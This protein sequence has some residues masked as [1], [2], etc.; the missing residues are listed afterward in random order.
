MPGV[1]SRSELQAAGNR[2]AWESCREADKGIREG[3]YG[4]VLHALSLSTGKLTYRRR[5]QLGGH[6]W[7]CLPDGGASEIWLVPSHLMPRGGAS[8]AAWYLW[9]GAQYQEPSL[10]LFAAAVVVDLLPP[11]RSPWSAPVS[12]F[13]LAVR[14]MPKVAL[15]IQPYIHTQNILPYSARIRRAR[16]PAAAAR[17]ATADARRT[18]PFPSWGCCSLTL[19][20]SPLGDRRGAFRTLV[21][22]RPP[23]RRSSHA[24][25]PVSTAHP[26]AWRRMQ[27]KH[28]PAMRGTSSLIILAELEPSIDEHHR[29]SAAPALC[30]ILDYAST[31]AVGQ[32]SSST[33][34]TLLLAP[35]AP[36]WAALYPSSLSFLPPSLPALHV[37][38]SLLFL[39]QFLNRS[40]QLGRRTKPQPDI[41][42]VS[43]SLP[44]RNFLKLDSTA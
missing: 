36:L 1:N 37:I 6:L 9:S 19:T 2:E 10:A 40:P 12:A 33:K 7:G 28:H 16:C 4:V 21:D 44:T 26:S 41:H 17:G 3:Y 5:R 30:L 34:Y 27:R 38:H 42:V 25:M 11:V 32:G 39:S 14:A 15:R 22:A 18:R 20:P 35:P 8:W 31:T 13:D 43:D 24:S 29:R 23:Y